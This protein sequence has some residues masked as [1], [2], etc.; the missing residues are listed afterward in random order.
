MS[1]ER[2]KTLEKLAAA[3][4]DVEVENIMLDYDDDGDE[5]ENE[6]SAAAAAADV[7]ALP[8]FII[9]DAEG[10][11]LVRDSGAMSLAGLE[12]LIARAKKRAAKR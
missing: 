10:E 2:M 11:E 1:M 5:I 12:R 4:P 9:T 7:Q 3:Y 8:T 6:K